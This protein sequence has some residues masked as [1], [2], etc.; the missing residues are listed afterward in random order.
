[1]GEGRKKKLTLG[2]AKEKIFL[3]KEERKGGE[4]RRRRE[5]KRGENGEERLK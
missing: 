3:V 2:K 5:C 4:R 1:M